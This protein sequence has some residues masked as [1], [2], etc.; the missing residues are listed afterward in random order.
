M[1]TIA[2]PRDIILAP[3]ISEKSYGLIEDD[4]YTFLVHPDANKTQIKIA[5]EKIFGVKV[6]SVNTLNRQGKRKRTRFGYGKRK[7][8]K[9]AIVTLA[10]GS[11]SIE[12]FGG[13][14]S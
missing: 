10:E 5:V 4:V 6:S 8:T 9:R 11:K 2:D 14:V 13:P 3:V 7:D 12:I 1:A